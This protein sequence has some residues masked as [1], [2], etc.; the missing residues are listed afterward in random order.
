MHKLPSYRP[1]FSRL[2]LSIMQTVFKKTE[3]VDDADNIAADYQINEAQMHSTTLIVNRESDIGNKKQ[4]LKNSQHQ[5][6]VTKKPQN[7]ESI[8]LEMQIQAITCL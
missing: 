4:N 2:Q 6:I 3:Y 1:Q 5:T 7:Y 8:S